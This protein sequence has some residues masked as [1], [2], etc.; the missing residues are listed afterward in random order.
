MT[1]VLPMMTFWMFLSCW[2]VIV[3]PFGW[4]CWCHFFEEISLSSCV[5]CFLFA[6]VFYVFHC[7][8]F[9]EFAPTLPPQI[10]TT[11]YGC[12]LFLLFSW[13]VPF[14]MNFDVFLRP[15]WRPK[16]QPD[17]TFPTRGTP[18]CPNDGQVVPKGSK[19]MPKGSP[20]YPKWFPNGPKW[21]PKGAQR[22]PRL[23]KM[24]SKWTKMMPKGCP[25]HTKWCPWCPMAP[26]GTRNP[27]KWC[28]NGPSGTENDAYGAQRRSKLTRKE[29]SRTAWSK[30][31]AHHR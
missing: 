20:G 2:N 23:L 18:R 5:F 16:I 8:C 3:L 13:E 14:L 19:M 29:S 26:Q 4:Y 22:L 10:D 31:C 1:H 6:H 7:H 12:Y 17:D 9:G 24:V 11:G 28:P 25:R 30:P 15:K 27:P 21:C